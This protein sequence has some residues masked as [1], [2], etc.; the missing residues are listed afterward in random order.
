MKSRGQV[1]F[2]IDEERFK[3]L[4][5]YENKIKKIPNIDDLN[6]RLNETKKLN[7]YSNIRVVSLCLACLIIISLIS[8]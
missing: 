6:A 3:Y 1:I 8:I 5:R 2:D 7:F 4:Y